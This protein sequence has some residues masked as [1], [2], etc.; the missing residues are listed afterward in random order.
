MFHMRQ[1]AAK[2]D[3]MVI[4][5]W[6]LIMTSAL[7]VDIFLSYIGNHLII[8]NIIILFFASSVVKVLRVKNRD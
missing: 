4:K 7:T 6:F 3:L 5:I 2:S 8:I 1:N